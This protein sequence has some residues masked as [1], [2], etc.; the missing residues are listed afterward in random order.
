MLPIRLPSPAL[1]GLA[2]FAAGVAA[3]LLRQPAAGL[4][5]GLLGSVG[6]LIAWFGF[7]RPMGAVVGLVVVIGAGHGA[8][9]RRQDGARCA[10]RMTEGAYRFEVLVRE[11]TPSG[12][13]GAVEPQAAG[14]AG[15]VMIRHRRPD[16]LWAGAR[17]IVEGTWRPRTGPWR[18]GG[19]VLAVRT[20]T[21]LDSVADAGLEARLRNRLLRTTGTLYGSRAG[22]I[23]ALVLGTR[24]TIDPTLGDA[25][26]RS[27]LVHLLSI[28]GFHVGLV[29]GW[30]LLILRAAGLGRRAAIGAAVVV[31][32]YVVFVGAAPPAV[33]AALLAIVLAVERH[34]QRNPSAGALFATV[35]FGV[36]LIDPWAVT[37]LGAWLSVT[38]LWGAT[39]A[40]R[41]SD[42]ALGSSQWWR[43]I[44][45][46]IG[47][48]LATAPFTALVFGTVPIA[49]VLLNLVAIPMTAFAVPAVIASLIVGPVVPVV[50][51]AFAAG[52]GTLLAAL[53]L[54]AVQGG[55]APGAALVFEPGLGPAMV[56]AAGVVVTVAVFGIRQT[57]REA[58][59]RLLW[60]GAILGCAH[61]LAAWLPVAHT[62]SRL[63]LH[64]LDVGQGDAALIETPAGRWM[65]ID[66]GPSDR[67]FDAGRRVIVPYLRRQGVRRLEA[68]FLS[69]GHRDHYGGLDA[70]L[71]AMP[72]GRVFEPGVRIPDPGYLAL[73][74]GITD[75][76]VAWSPLRAGAQLTID[77][78]TVEALH[79]DTTWSDWGLDLN[80]DSSV[81]R[82]TTGDFQALF[83]G[84]AGFPVEE[85][86][87]TRLG[88]MEL[89]KVGHHGSRTASGDRLLGAL[90]PLVA[91][92]SV[93]AS[94]R[95]GHP[96]PEA[97]ERLE[98]AGAAVWRTDRDGTVTVQVEDTFMVIRGRRG[99]ATYPITP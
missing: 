26:S 71:D 83:P 53:E 81:L 41:W 99:R 45:G 60:V 66:A 12:Q 4:I 16:T 11:P 39:A 24:G 35:A 50:A 75:R 84:D 78:V 86:L 14:C 36:V 56:A 31:V 90:R 25:F 62:G 49:G 5:V 27:G 15:V 47:A 68:V 74:D 19:G 55:S 72:V 95:Y 97:L 88:R 8:L 13:M 70:V 29:W 80:E 28:S 9:A 89:L 37:D 48:T 2:A 38:A 61:S 52:G 93:G 1:V 85:A 67:Q 20:V 76:E 33:R 79:P 30:V 17:G 23:Q 57:A 22:V 94:N 42:R 98:T 10:E 65:L 43:V 6:A 91:V 96:T 64:F 77:G 59:R 32:A 87:A 58:A 82:I 69:H 21:V 18:A 63:T 73:L 3:G 40:S 51:G 92:V 54:L 46:S 44:T 7:R 34:R